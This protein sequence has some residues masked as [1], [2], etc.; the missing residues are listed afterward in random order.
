[1]LRE[2][3]KTKALEQFN[4]E[5]DVL[6]QFIK[7]EPIENGLTVRQLLLTYFESEGALATIERRRPTLTI[8]VPRLPEDCFSA[9]IW[10]TAE[11]VPAVALHVTEHIHT[12]IFGD[13]GGE[14]EGIDEVLVEAGFIPAFPTVVLKN[15][16]WVVV[17]EGTRTRSAALDNPNSDFIF[18]FVDEY[19]DNSKKEKQAT[20]RQTTLIIDPRLRE[21]FDIYERADGWQ[22]DYIYYNLTPVN[23]TGRIVRT[24]EE[25]LTSFRF[26]SQITPEHALSLL[27]SEHNANDPKL[28]LGSGSPPGYPWTKGHYKFNVGIGSST[29]GAPQF[30]ETFF[31]VNPEQLFEVTYEISTQK[32]LFVTLRSYRARVVGFKTA[33]PRVKLMNWDLSQYTPEVKISIAKENPSV[34]RTLTSTITT[35]YAGNVSGETK[36]GLKFGESIKTTKV[37]SVQTVTREDDR[38]LGDVLLH[39]GDK[40]VLG[41]AGFFFGTTWRLR[42]YDT[43][44]YAITVMP[45]RVE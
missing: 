29:P 43:G 15:N 24:F 45:V 37:N 32:F 42:E 40:V 31:V 16:A 34:T 28:L 25:H 19:F 10:N 36:S 44:V 26:S 21:A 33:H 14:G 17:A 18:E 5:Y 7:D 27:T 20:T 11:E 35:E 8:F 4:K 3:I 41:Q 38:K 1:M 6:Y 13:F 23:P 39:F 9:E 2:I 22:R 30:L 12:P